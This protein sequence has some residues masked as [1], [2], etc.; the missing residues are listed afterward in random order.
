MAQWHWWPVGWDARL[1]DGT[2]VTLLEDGDHSGTAEAT[3]G[4]L[5]GGAVG[6]RTTVATAVG[7]SVSGKLGV[8]LQ[9]LTFQ[10]ALDLRRDDTPYKFSGSAQWA[11]SVDAQLLLAGA[12]WSAAA[13]RAGDRLGAVVGVARLLAAG[14]RLDLLSRWYTAG[15]FSPLGSA[16]TGAD[17]DA[18]RGLTVQATGRY[19]KGWNWRAW[20]DA[21]DRTA[22]RWRQPLPGV[23]RGA[24]VHGGW[25]HEAWHV[26]ADGQQRQRHQRT[27]GDPTVERTRRVRLQAQ[28]SGEYLRVT[29]RVDGVAWRRRWPSVADRS[30]PINQQGLSASAGLRWRRHPVRLDG[31]LSAFS[32]GGYGARIY[33]YEPQVPGSVSIR[34]Q[35]GRGVRFVGVAMVRHRDCEFTVRW[36]WNRSRAGSQRRLTIQIDRAAGLR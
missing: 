23:R 26:S 31:L 35:Y 36:R 21:T 14:V 29:M 15:F 25:R 20:F 5:H 8:S 16:P 28:R 3:R 17:M 24:G 7:Q 18:E 12:R 13:A 2:V 27:G 6:L 10:R 4:R 34:P 33:Q 11:G 19:A 32:T 9:R 22:P 1:R 30:L